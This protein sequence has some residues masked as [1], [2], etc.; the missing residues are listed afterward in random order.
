[1]IFAIAQKDPA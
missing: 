1:M